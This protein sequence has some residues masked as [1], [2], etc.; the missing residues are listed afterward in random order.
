M[1]KNWIKGAIK[2][3]GALKKKAKE[4]GGL[5]KNGTIKES[6]LDKA[7]NSKNPKTRKQAVLAKTL[8]KMR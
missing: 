7:E 6:Y 8:K 3:P 2:N 4:S 5:K 1:D